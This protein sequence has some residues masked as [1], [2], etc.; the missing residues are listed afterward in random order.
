ML[1]LLSV[2]KMAGS[3]RFVC[4]CGKH[5][6]VKKVAGLVRGIAR[7]RLRQTR[8][9]AYMT[10]EQEIIVEFFHLCF[11]DPVMALRRDLLRHLHRLPMRPYFAYSSHRVGV[12]GRL[13]GEPGLMR[14]CSA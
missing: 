12:A 5:G 6:E 10:Q 9:E 11:K 13:V 1:R 2:Y 8:K 4:S 7:C 14:R 3:Y